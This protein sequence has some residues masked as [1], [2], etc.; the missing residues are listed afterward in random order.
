MVLWGNRVENDERKKEKRGRR[1]QNRK[2]GGGAR[3]LD[4]FEGFLFFSLSP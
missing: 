3:L 4:L 2:E 1:R